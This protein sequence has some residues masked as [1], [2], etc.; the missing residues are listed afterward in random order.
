MTD[1]LFTLEKPE[2]SYLIG[3]GQADGHL[4]SN[5]RNRGQFSIELKKEDGDILIKFKELVPVN[6]S[7]TF[8]TRK[9]NFK[10]ISET[11]T[12]TVCFKSF[13]D[14][15]NFYGIPYGKKSNLIEPPKKEY[16][17]KD[18]WRGI[19]D[20]DGSLGVT[21]QG[22]PFLSLVT[23]SEKLYNSFSALIF[24]ETNFKINLQ[25]NTRDNV[26]NITLYKEKAQ[27]L[28][29]FLYYENCLCLNRK[30]E[31]A[32]ICLNWERPETLKTREHAPKWTK[33]E[34]EILKNNSILD[35][36]EKIKRTE[37]SI[38]IKKQRLKNKDKHG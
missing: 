12:W 31:K 32:N 8:R 24:K 26:Y 1:L 27:K 15:I 18:Y 2:F 35:C 38:R 34:I 9:T 4:S 37:N 16:I 14:T 23:A 13:R 29:S 7:I 10:K 5:T 25:P 11:I 28:I 36:L 17:E 19:I 3:F 20:A 6:S 30:K 21:K 22:Y 33:E